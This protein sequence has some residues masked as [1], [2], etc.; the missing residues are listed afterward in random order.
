[1]EP[2]VGFVPLRAAADMVGR[3]LS[4]SKW[5]PIDELA[6]DVIPAKLNPEV[7]RV[8]AAIAEQCELGKI[9]VVYRSITGFEALDM[10]VW[11]APAWR[12]YFST[13]MIELDL[14]LLDDKLRPNKE[15]LTAKC[16]RDVFVRK[17]NLDQFV[18]GLPRPPLV[19]RPRYPSD[20]PL[21]QE[22]LEAI[23]SGRVNGALPAAKLVYGRAQGGPSPESNLDRLR[24]AIAAELKARSSPIIAKT[25]PNT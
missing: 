6:A 3:K 18:A 21:I 19:N 4:G 11:R 9:A 25:S 24:K 2:P 23:E 5:R 10:T 8:I 16:Q 14:P 12:D 17:E 1:M 7:D 22:G 20:E 15:G 13:G